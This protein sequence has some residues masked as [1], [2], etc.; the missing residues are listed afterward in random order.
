MRTLDI[1]VGLTAI[2]LISPAIRFAAEKG[3]AFPGL[4]GERKRRKIGGQGGERQQVYSAVTFLV[5][6]VNPQRAEQHEE[7]EM[8][9]HG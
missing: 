7:R 3:D 1:M 8:Q 5:P 6:G 4:R 2:A 9:F